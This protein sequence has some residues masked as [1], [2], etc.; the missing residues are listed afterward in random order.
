MTAALNAIMKQ[1]YQLSERDEALGKLP[2]VLNP[3]RAVLAAVILT[4]QS[5][6]FR[7]TIW[8]NLA[9]SS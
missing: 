4:R 2:D 7:Y 8:C 1:E 9:A 5:S 3:G 6:F